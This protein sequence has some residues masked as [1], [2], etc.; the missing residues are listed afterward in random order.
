ML[1]IVNE[2]NTLFFCYVFFVCDTNLYFSNILD[3]QERKSNLKKHIKTYYNKRIKQIERFKVEN[4]R[5]EKKKKKFRLD[6][7][8]KIFPSLVLTIPLSQ[9]YSQINNKVI[10]NVKLEGLGPEKVSVK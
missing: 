8:H 6:T 7:S 3:I 9:V 4:E 10:S 1:S 2:V 5:K